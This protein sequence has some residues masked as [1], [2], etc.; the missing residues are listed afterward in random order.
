LGGIA[1][2]YALEELR[3]LLASCSIV[4]A[5]VN[6]GNSS[7]LA[8][9]THPYGEYWPIAV[10]HVTQS[11]V[12][13]CNFKLVD[14]ALSVSG[15][16]PQREGHIKN[17]WTNEYIANEEQIAVEGASSLTAEALSTALY[18]APA[19]ERPHILGNYENYKAYTIIC[20]KESKTKI[21]EI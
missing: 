18:A 6:F 13:A 17:P 2:G 16:T 10:E 20:G 21:T 9:G 5:L 7:V 19:C 3:Q 11:G 8:V 14:N 1:K 15:L 12:A 4:R